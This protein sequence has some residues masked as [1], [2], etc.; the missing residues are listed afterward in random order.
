[1]ATVTK[2]HKHS[3]RPINRGRPGEIVTVEG[4]KIWKPYIEMNTSE[5]REATAEFDEEIDESKFRPM[6]AQERRQWNRI[7]RG[8]GRPKIGK[9]VKVISV[10]VEKG[11][12]AKVDQFAKK[13]NLSRAQ[14]ITHG[15]EAVLYRNRASDF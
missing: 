1:M 7:R 14:L 9:G 11:L 3:K 6:N 13:S 2:L 8:R 4:E 10:S 12:L 15:L 5:L